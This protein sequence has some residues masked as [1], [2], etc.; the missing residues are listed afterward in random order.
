MNMTD[1]EKIADDILD[2]I[3]LNKPGN[4]SGEI[5]LTKED[6]KNHLVRAANIGRIQIPGCIPDFEWI[7]QAADRKVQAVYDEYG[8]EREKDFSLGDIR[9]VV[10]ALVLWQDE[11]PF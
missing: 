5:C 10:E 4:P 9:S 7:R 3:T 11:M 6:L 8:W 2:S 1:I